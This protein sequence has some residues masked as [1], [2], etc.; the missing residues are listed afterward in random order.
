MR[1]SDERGRIEFLLR[2]DGVVSTRAWVS[3]TLKIYRRAVLNVQH[4][5]HTPGYRAEF[6]R[7]YCA[8]KHWLAT[9]RGAAP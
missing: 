6:I 9:T 3:R 8:F 5:A 2:R 1:M 7:A 4:H